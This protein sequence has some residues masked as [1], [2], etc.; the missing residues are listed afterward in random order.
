MPRRRR[1]WV[2]FF[3]C[4]LASLYRI[5]VTINSK[6][7]SCRRSNVAILD[8]AIPDLVISVNMLYQLHTFRTLNS[9]YP[10]RH[11]FRLPLKQNELSS[12]M[13]IFRMTCPRS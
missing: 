6:K 2:T 7:H 11:L 12:L 4:L 8:L 9:N 5:Y 10:Q 3:H 13:Q 1:A